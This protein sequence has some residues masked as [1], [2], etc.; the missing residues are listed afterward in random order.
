MDSMREEISRVLAMEQTNTSAI[1]ELR[2][3]IT[4]LRDVIGELG[5][6]AALQGQALVGIKEVFTREVSQLQTEQTG[7]AAAQEKAAELS[8]HREELAKQELAGKF[9]EV[10]TRLGNVEANASRASGYWEGSKYIL[11][12][13]LLSA[14]GLIVFMLEHVKFGS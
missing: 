12:F 10:E 4:S 13:A 3:A 2:M 1:N 7:M 5:M 8:S 14:G 6:N 11:G 9:K